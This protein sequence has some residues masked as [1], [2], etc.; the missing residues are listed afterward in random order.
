MATQELT[1]GLTGAVV[2]ASGDYTTAQAAQKM[3]AG[4]I[5][6]KYGRGQ[7]LQSDDLGVR[8]MLE[9]GYEPEAMIRVMEILMEASGDA[10]RKPEF[11]STHPDPENRMEKIR[12]A[13]RKYRGK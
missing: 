1:Q 12:E 13:I 5:S 6:M 8:F 9:A 3:I 2:I 7:E 4:L 10:Q 11:Q